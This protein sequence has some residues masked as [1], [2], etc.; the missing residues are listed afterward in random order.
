MNNAL[1]SQFH[2]IPRR[3]KTRKTISTHNFPPNDKISNS[4]NISTNDTCGKPQNEPHDTTKNELNDT[5]H[6]EP[7]RPSTQGL[8]ITKGYVAGITAL[9]LI[10]DGAEIKHISKEFCRRA[11]IALQKENYEATIA[12]TTKEQLESTVTKIP[13]SIG[14]YTESMRLA[15][16]KL[17]Y[18][19][20]IDKNGSANK[21]LK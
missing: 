2:K 16:N 1:L 18:D 8:L 4:V 6:D 21:K 7:F 20:I 10:D 14:P 17:H 12:N 9:I 11:R 13:I 15:A 19:V 3:K 5:L